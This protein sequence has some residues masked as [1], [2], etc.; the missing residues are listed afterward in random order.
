MRRAITKKTLLVSVMHAN[1]EVGTIEPTAEI[2]KVARESGTCFHTDAVQTAGHVPVKVDDLGVD[3]LAMSA[4][5]LGGPKGV[6]ALYVRKGTRV[7]VVHARRGAGERAQSQHRKCA[8]NRGFWQS[9][10][11][12]TARVRQRGKAP[13]TLRDRLA[14]RPH[15]AC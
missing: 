3:M 5:K 1:N 2:S 7:V 4:H 15:T 9:R 8:W 10:G 14:Q 6:G 11:D 13:T 12:S